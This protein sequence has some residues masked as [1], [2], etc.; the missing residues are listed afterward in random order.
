M[1]PPPRLDSRARPCDADQM[2]ELKANDRVSHYR[3]IDRIGQGG[4][5]QVWLAE[6]TSLPRRVVVK[7]VHP[8]LAED[9][10]V[11]ERLLRE[12]RAAASVDHPNV[13]TV[14]EAGVHE[15]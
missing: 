10:Q 15:G 6:D 1:I 12:A 8:H 14:Y 5:G 2:P 9:P 13:V 11:T 3:L 4:M 7:L